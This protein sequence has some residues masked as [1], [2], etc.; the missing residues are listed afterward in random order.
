MTSGMIIVLV[1]GHVVAD[2]YMQN[3]TIAQKKDSGIKHLLL[4]GLG[5]LLVYMVLLVPVWRLYGLVSALILAVLHV[6]TDLFKR[7]LVK[8]ELKEGL[9][10]SVDQLMHLT[11]LSIAALVMT[12]VFRPA[13]D[14][15][16][17]FWGQLLMSWI[18]PPIL[19]ILLVLKPANITFRKLY[20]QNKPELEVNAEEAQQLVGSDSIHEKDL[21]TG[22]QI[23]NLERLLIVAFIMLNQFT[24][25]ALVLTAKSITRYGRISDD[26]EFAEYYLL[27][28]LFSLLY[29]VVVGLWLLQ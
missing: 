20:G 25:I 13:N 23:G 14:P 9:I 18:I 29:T 27:G 22:K 26:K 21:Q 3:D 6:L 24:A 17:M 19:A 7:V 11:I 8:K 1:L 4:H 2:Y 16:A 15:V 10:Y 28:T 5:H 12:Y